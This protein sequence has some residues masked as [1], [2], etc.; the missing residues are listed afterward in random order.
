[1][2]TTPNA[3]A[4]TSPDPPPVGYPSAE[5]LDSGG[6]S[7]AAG[8]SADLYLVPADESPDGRPR[9]TMHSGYGTTGTPLMAYRRRWLHVGSYGPAVV[10]Q[11]VLAW[12][13]RHE[14]RLL[15]LSDTYDGAA[16]DGH[17][18]VGQWDAD[19]CR[20]ELGIDDDDLATY[21]PASEY[22][23]GDPQSV[24]DVAL[25][26]GIAAAVEHE[27]ASTGDDIVIAE[28]DAHGAL[29]ALLEERAERLEDTD[30]ARERLERIRIK[31]VLREG[32]V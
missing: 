12:L 13:R 5:T 7:A 14:Q 21:W 1:M 6:I 24:I 15:S 11:S 28:A 19:P 29:V 9:V 20:E 3:S 27:V 16:W 22:F 23:A 26:H 4:C 31:R 32:G 10:G 2:S 8:W 18:Y 30:D 17:D 25:A